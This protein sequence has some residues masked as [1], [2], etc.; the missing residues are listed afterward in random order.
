MPQVE[1]VISRGPLSVHCNASFYLRIATM[2]KVGG[3][4]NHTGAKHTGAC[5]STSALNHMGV[6]AQVPHL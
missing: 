4:A 1:P 6:Q 2:K 5:A 3:G